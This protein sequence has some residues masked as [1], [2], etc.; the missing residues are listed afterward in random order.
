MRKPEILAPAAKRKA[1]LARPSLVPGAEV[2]LN[3]VKADGSP[4]VLVGTVEEVKGSGDKEVVIMKTAEGYRS[5][6]L[7][8]IKSV[9]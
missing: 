6:N 2:T 4:R 5:A 8:R 1:T 9:R 7:H 3:Y